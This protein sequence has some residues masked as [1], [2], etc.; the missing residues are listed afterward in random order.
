MEAAHVFPF[1]EG[2]RALS[3]RGSWSG[4][5]CLIERWIDK[6]LYWRKPRVVATGWLGDMWRESVDQE[7]HDAMFSVIRQASAAHQFLM[8]TKNPVAMADALDGLES[9]SLGDGTEFSAL[10][11]WFGTTVTNQADS[12]KLI[13]HLLRIPGKRWLCVEPLLVPVDFGWTCPKCGYTVHDCQTLLD[14]QLCG[15][16]TPPAPRV[17]WIVVGQGTNGYKPAKPEWIQSVIDQAKA[18]GVPVWTKA[19]PPGVEPVRQAPP[20]IA[21]ILRTDKRIAAEC[22]AAGGIEG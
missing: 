9:D 19:L 14:H 15:A 12:D 1:G 22:E 11:L 20:E 16:P 13:P 6:P 5:H 21:A 2:A 18:A 4:R 3:G 10:N 7:D 8:L 17:D